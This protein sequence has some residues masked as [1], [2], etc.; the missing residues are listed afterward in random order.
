MRV[1]K[2]LLLNYEDLS[3]VKVIIDNK[4]LHYFKRHLNEI[5]DLLFRSMVWKNFFDMV[6][7]ANLKSPS[8]IEI[9]LNNLFQEK[10]DA[11]LEENLNHAKS[12]L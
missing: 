12:S 4:S 9:L 6:V 11:V 8:Y 1:S 2:A 10:S 3:F 5:D 7:D